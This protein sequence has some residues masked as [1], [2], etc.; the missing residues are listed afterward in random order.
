PVAKH[1]QGFTLV[2]LLVVIALIA[3]LAGL[4]LPE[5]SRAKA[6]A[7]STKCKSNLRQMGLAMQLYVN[8]YDQRYPYYSYYSRS[9]V[10]FDWIADATKWEMAIAPYYQPYWWTNIMCRC[11]NFPDFGNLLPNTPIDWKQMG[12][13]G[14]NRC[15]T[16]LGL[17]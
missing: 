8:D 4:L 6:K 15:Y 11:P 17:G 1:S 12:T 3:L 10:S 5:L 14:Y 9:S 13:Y 16:G 2:E 7:Y